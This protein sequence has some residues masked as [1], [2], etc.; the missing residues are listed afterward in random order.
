MKKTIVFDFDGVI[1]SYTSGW[2]GAA[3]IPDPP[4]PG[5]IEALQEICEA[6]YE[7][8]IVSSRCATEEGKAAIQDYLTKH[9][10]H[11][12]VSRICTEKPPAIV[13]IDDRAICFDGNASNLLEQIQ[14]FRPWYQKE[15][16]F[17][18]WNDTKSI[19]PAPGEIV[20]GYCQR[21][22]K[23]FVGYA[24]ESYRGK[25]YWTHI[26]AS[27][28]LYSVKSKVTH[29]MPLPALPDGD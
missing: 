11:Q 27:G 16:A 10:M 20:L 25:P 23:M 28:A 19:L 21:T 1:H 14:T 29:W 2:Q 13:Y 3:T 17:R 7:I 4:T 22:N 24:D 9:H 15:S 12:Y 6:G 26:G 18:G 5:I 8:V